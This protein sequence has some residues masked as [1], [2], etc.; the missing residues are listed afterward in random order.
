MNALSH[1]R[2]AYSASAAPIRTAGKLEFEAI[3]R[4]TR[5]MQ[6]AAKK[7]RP[8]FG[9]LVEALHDNTRMWNI[10]AIDVADPNNSLPKE[11]RAN[12]FYL[13]EFTNHHT[14]K[15]LAREASVDPLVEINTSILRGLSKGAIK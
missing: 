13:A 12:L 14:S 7:G 1:A 2:H 11:L 4:I 6:V 15:V 3:A 5:K 8:G 10:F 9:A